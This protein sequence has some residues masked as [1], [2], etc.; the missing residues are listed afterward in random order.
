M[1][2]I[3]CLF[4]H[5]IVCLSTNPV[6]YVVF[7]EDDCVGHIYFLGSSVRL[8]VTASLC[9]SFSSWLL[10]P[11]GY[12]F[13]KVICHYTV[14]PFWFDD[15][16]RRYR[17]LTF[18]G[19]TFQ[20]VIMCEIVRP[21]AFIFNRI[22][23]HDVSSVISFSRDVAPFGHTIIYFLL[24]NYSNYAIRFG[25]DKKQKVLINCLLTGSCTIKTAQLKVCGTGHQ[26]V[27]TLSWC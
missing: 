2:I 13:S 19:K 26:V 1:L 21:R 25:V 7:P 11:K 12:I 15:I 24:K 23:S 3:V 22:I 27:T 8:S 10:R 16:C 9:E 17:S 6:V 20:I 5:C 14:P 18:S 4:G